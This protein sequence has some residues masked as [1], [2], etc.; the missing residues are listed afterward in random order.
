[1]IGAATPDMSQS[2]PATAAGGLVLLVLLFLPA[3]P[4][5]WRRLRDAWRDLRRPLP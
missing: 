5:A 2:L 3:L 4:L 1:M